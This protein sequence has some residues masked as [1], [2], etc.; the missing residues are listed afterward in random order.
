MKSSGVNNLPQQSTQETTRTTPTVTQSSSTTTDYNRS[1]ADTDRNA[2][3]PSRYETE[4]NEKTNTVLQKGGPYGDFG[5]NF[6]D[7]DRPISSST[8]VYSNSPATATTVAAPMATSAI[9]EHTVT[10][11]TQQPR[12]TGPTLV[13][14]HP[15]LT[16]QIPEGTTILNY[17]GAPASAPAIVQPEQRAV[18]PTSGVQQGTTHDRYMKSTNT[19]LP[20]VGKN[21]AVG[22]Y[23]TNEKSQPHSNNV[24]SVLYPTESVTGTAPVVQQGTYPT[25]GTLSGM[26]GTGT[27]S[28]N[29]KYRDYSHG[30]TA[31]GMYG[32]RPGNT[33]AENNF[34]ENRAAFDGGVYGSTGVTGV[35]HSTEYPPA[36][37]DHTHS[38]HT[39]TSTVTSETRRTPTSSPLGGMYDKN[40]V[41]VE[42]SHQ[43][44]DIRG[45]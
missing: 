40:E 45:V 5:S 41:D 38:T 42:P 36:T 31:I 22:N 26:T 25:A 39:A 6:H 13:S 27:G 24:Q 16:P 1:A 37:H 17:S 21:G 10:T 11:T 23:I 4:Y 43:P 44:R 2:Y 35:R 12:Q 20:A 9:E 32:D 7:R 19:Y 28:A 8:S 3:N 18:G 15:I 33:A 14:A 30:D 29:T 34:P